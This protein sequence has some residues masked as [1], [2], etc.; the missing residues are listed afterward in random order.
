LHQAGALDSVAAANR[1]LKAADEGA[2]HDEEIAHWL[3]ELA[4][5]AGG[6]A[7]AEERRETEAGV[8][9]EDW[10]Q[11][12]V[13]AVGQVIRPFEQAETRQATGVI[14]LATLLLAAAWQPQDR[15][16]GRWLEAA[17]LILAQWISDLLLVWPPSGA[18]GETSGGERRWRKLFR[19]SGA[20][21]GVMVAV[22][23]LF[24][25]GAF[26]QVIFGHPTARWL[27]F[28]I[29]GA[30]VAFA[31][32][33]GLKVQAG[34]IHVQDQAFYRRASTQVTLFVLLAQALLPVFFVLAAPQ[35]ATGYLVVISAALA[36]LWGLL[37]RG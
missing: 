37:R 24:F 8:P 4:N 19:L 35:I 7:I 10:A 3:P 34:A 5:K 18:E 33:G 25:T 15:W 26:V 28:L 20:A 32:A 13:E 2:L 30:G 21:A 27:S 22:G 17:L 9:V 12:F 16:S 11:R 6:G 14:I 29:L 23:V 36:L 1:L 31:Y